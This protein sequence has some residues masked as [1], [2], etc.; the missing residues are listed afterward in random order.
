MLCAFIRIVRAP[1]VIGSFCLRRVWGWISRLTIAKDSQTPATGACKNDIESDAAQHINAPKIG[2]ATFDTDKFPSITEYEQ[3][4]AKKDFIDHLDLDAVCALASQFN[5]GSKC[6]VVS[7]NNG[8]FNVCFFV[9]F[10][11]GGPKW[12]VRVPIE[13]AAQDSW[14]KLLSE[15][16]TLQYIERNSHI[17]VPH[18]HAYGRDAKLCKNSSETH[19]F[20]IADFIPGEPLD[21]KLLVSTEE[22]CRKLF[23]SEL[24]DILAE[25]RTLEFP[26]LGSL[27]PDPSGRQ[28]AIVGPVMSMTAA[29]LRLPP[30]PVLA[31][32]KQ[33]MDHQLNLFSKFLMQPSGGIALDEVRQELFA[34]YGMEHV[35]HQ[36]FT[37]PSWI[38]GHD[39]LETNKQMNLEFRQVLEEKSKTC[40][41]CSLLEREWYS[42][43]DAKDIPIGPTD[44]AFCAAHVLRRPAGVTDVF[45]DYF[46]ASKSEKSLEDQISDF[47]EKRPSLALEAQRRVKH[48]ERY[49]SYLKEQG[50]YET[51]IDALLAASKALKEKWG[52][53]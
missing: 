23:Y 44:V 11:Q 10:D 17:P 32:A 27:V 49:A 31:S 41:L 1:W 50:R 36:V 30:F 16:T 48:S 15:V 24:I 43:P 28:Q 13:P 51:D 33:Y 37:P 4:L 19:A 40:G 46:A 47:F 26:A 9:E 38:T 45:C 6:R 39:S 29:I 18:V 14:G 7:K 35:F 53:S 12:A 22:R 42:Q 21:K 8:S 2:A 5:N 25:L 3:G 52:W 20:L 34:L